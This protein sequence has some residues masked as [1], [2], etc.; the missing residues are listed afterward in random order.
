MF[1]AITKKKEV[2]VNIRNEFVRIWIR[3]I[4]V[5]IIL[6]KINIGFLPILS[7]HLCRKIEVKL[8]N[9]AMTPIYDK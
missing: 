2:I 6:V 5:K 4:V 7:A 8:P 9:P 3:G 1:A